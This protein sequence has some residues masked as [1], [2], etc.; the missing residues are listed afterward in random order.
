MVLI[1]ATSIFSCC[2]KTQNGLT[3][4]Y[5]LIQVVLRMAVKMSLY[6]VSQKWVFSHNLKQ[7]KPML[8]VFDAQYHDIPSF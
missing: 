7:L 4:W 6:H 5:R 8:I 3:F 2:D 1:T